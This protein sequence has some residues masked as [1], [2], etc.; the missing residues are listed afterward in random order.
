MH[1]LINPDTRET[2]PRR[3]RLF[4]RKAAL[5]ATTSIA[6]IGLLGGGVA[7]AGAGGSSSNPVYSAC[8]THGAHHSMYH[9]TKNGTPQC[10]HKDKTITWNHTGPAGPHGIAGAKGDTGATGP[11]GPKGDT[12]PAGPIGPQGP[13]GDTGPA[14]PQGPP[15]GITGLSWHTYQFTVPSGPDANYTTHLP[16]SDGQQTYGGG[17][18][19]ENPDGDQAVTESAPSGD[20]TSWYVEITNNS[21]FV[22]FTGHAYVLCGPPGLTID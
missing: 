14:G 12:G 13:K 11:Q 15:G 19:V 5:A 1:M 4:T 3:R 10:H 7:Y 6:A 2:E 20:L 18:W 8:V 21:P 17:A 22:T 9:V 16:C